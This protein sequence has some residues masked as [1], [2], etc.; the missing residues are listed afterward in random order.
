MFIVFIVLANAEC[1][2]DIELLVDGNPWPSN[3]V[4]FKPV[5]SNGSFVRCQ[6]CNDNFTDNPNWVGIKL[7]DDKMQ[8]VCKSKAENGSR[9]LQFSSFMK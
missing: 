4:L 6:Q 2:F 7:I 1:T 3:D 5:G 9:D 8:M